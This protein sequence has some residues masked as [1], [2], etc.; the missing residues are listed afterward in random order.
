MVCYDEPWIKSQ[1][2]FGPNVYF[3]YIFSFEIV[4]ITKGQ[5]SLN[6]VVIKRKT[7][8]FLQTLN[9]KVKVTD[10]ATVMLWSEDH[11]S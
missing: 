8:I 5:I 4:K 1:T 2:L 7:G 6:V 9:H 3:Y 10:K 11:S